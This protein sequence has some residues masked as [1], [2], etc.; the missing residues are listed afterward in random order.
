MAPKTPAAK[1]AAKAKPTK[2]APTKAD[3]PPRPQAAPTP[4]EVGFAGRLSKM[5]GKLKYMQGAKK[6]SDTDKEDR[7]H[8]SKQALA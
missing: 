2:A 8:A 6:S 4:C 1:R 5:L 3:P 7:T